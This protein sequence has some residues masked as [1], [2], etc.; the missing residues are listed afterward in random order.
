MAPS[1]Q[2]LEDG[3]ELR[4]V[5]EA[6]AAAAPA[7]ELRLHLLEPDPRMLV[8]QP[9]DGVEGEGADMGLVQGVESRSRRR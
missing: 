6:V 3:G 1:T 8:E 4:A 2:P 9:V 7:D 5:L